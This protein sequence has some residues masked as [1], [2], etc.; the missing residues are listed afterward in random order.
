MKLAQYNEYVISIV[1]TDGISSRSAG[2][3]LVH[4][5]SFKA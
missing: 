2:Y 1:D 3:V 4:F 5:L